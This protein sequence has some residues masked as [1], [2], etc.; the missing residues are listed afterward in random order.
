M[1]GKERYVFQH[2]LVRFLFYSAVTRSVPQKVRQLIRQMFPSVD[3]AQI[4]KQAE[5]GNSI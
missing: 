2:T 1:K 4:K 5:R 3:V